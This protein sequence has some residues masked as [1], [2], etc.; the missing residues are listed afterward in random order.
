MALQG[1]YV[2]AQA[3]HSSVYDAAYDGLQIPLARDGHARVKVSL[4]LLVLLVEKHTYY[5]RF[6]AL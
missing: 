5:V 1:I 3:F 4:N 6:S 2:D